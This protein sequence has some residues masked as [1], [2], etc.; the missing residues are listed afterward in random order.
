MYECVLHIL[1]SGLNYQVTVTDKYVRI[2]CEFHLTGEWAEFDDKRI[3]QMDGK[4]ALKFWKANKSV[5]MTLAE[6]HQIKSCKQ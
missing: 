4:S 2:G 3:L 1:I 5:I 6:N